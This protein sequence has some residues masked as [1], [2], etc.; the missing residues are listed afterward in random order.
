[1]AIK[2]NKDILGVK[3]KEVEHKIGQYADDT[4][5]TLDG[6]RRSLQEAL[7]TFAKFEMCS[8]LRA[9]VDKTLAVSLGSKVKE[10]ANSCLNLNIKFVTEFTLL[11]IK[12][13]INLASMLKLN[14]ENQLK[15]IEKLFVLYKRRNLSIMGRVTVVKTLALP[16]LPSP[17]EATIKKIDAMFSQFIWNSKTG[18]VSRNPL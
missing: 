4:F 14:I 11:G 1:M 6:S 3:I 5:L 15:K 18:K 7:D 2:N 8:G 13:S 16:K 10:K 17:D 9:N 12:F